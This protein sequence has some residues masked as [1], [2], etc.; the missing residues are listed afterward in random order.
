[1]S[2]ITI[3]D[4]DHFTLWFH[5]DTKIVHH[6]IK[7]YCYGVTLRT[8]LNK[9]VEELVK[10]GATK[11]LS[12]DRNNNTLTKEDTDWANGDWFPRCI[13]AGWKFWGLV[14]PEKAIGKM[15]MK[16]FVAQFAESGLT[17]QVFSDPDAALRWLAMAK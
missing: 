11:W 13:K 2:K 6:H 8:L 9:G 16:K 14:L 5:S 12:D 7:K 10:N 4:D 15:N 3:L 17:V 1:M